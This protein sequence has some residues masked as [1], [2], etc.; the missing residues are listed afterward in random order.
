MV[1]QDAYNRS[2]NIVEEVD[3]HHLFQD[4]FLIK[5]C[6]THLTHSISDKGVHILQEMLLHDLFSGIVIANDIQIVLERAVEQRMPISTVDYRLD[7]DPADI[8]LLIDSPILGTIV[9]IYDIFH[10]PEKISHRHR[11]EI[12]IRVLVQRRQ[13]REVLY[14]FRYVPEV[15]FKREGA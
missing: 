5:F 13:L 10:H 9:G 3:A 7:K 1:I 6:R 4:V 12:I 2:D 15:L 8:H 14:T 11:T